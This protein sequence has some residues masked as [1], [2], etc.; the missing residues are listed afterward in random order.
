YQI[1]PLR[2]LRLLFNESSI[3]SIRAFDSETQASGGFVNEAA[4]SPVRWKGAQ[5]TVADWL[6]HAEAW[7]AEEGVKLPKSAAGVIRVGSGLGLTD[8]GA[9]PVPRFQGN[10]EMAMGEMRDWQD[11]GYK[12]VLFSLNRGEDERVQELLEGKNKGCQFLIGPLR[13]GF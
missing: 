11:K 1:E 2:A 8:F 3:D 13:S 4:V 5:G 9:R 6:S 12:L 7:I 10:L